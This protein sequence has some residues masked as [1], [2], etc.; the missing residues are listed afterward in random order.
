MHPYIYRSRNDALPVSS[1]AN[2]SVYDKEELLRH[3]KISISGWHS[4]SEV[5]GSSEIE[6]TEDQITVRGFQSREAG[7]ESLLLD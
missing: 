7:I 5:L 1:T 2:R 4:T 3:P 6:T